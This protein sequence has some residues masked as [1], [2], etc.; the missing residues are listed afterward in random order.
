M[1]NLYYVGAF[2]FLNLIFVFFIDQIKNFI[3][4]FDKADGV[5]K[6]QEKPVAPIGGVIILFNLL[7]LLLIAFFDQNSLIFGKPFFKISNEFYLRGYFSFFVSAIVF[8]IIGLYDDKKNLKPIT[9]VFLLLFIS[10]CIILIDETLILK[11]LIFFSVN[12][13][14]ILNNFSYIFTILCILFLINAFNLYDGINLQSGINFIIIYVY[15][16]SKGIFPLLI[17]PFIIGNIFFLYLNFKNKIFFGDNGVYIN[18]FIIGYFVIKSYNHNADTSLKCDEVLLLFLLP[19]LDALRLFIFRIL[20]LKNPFV[21]DRN[22]IHHILLERLGNIYIVNFV[23]ALLVIIPLIFYN[24]MGFNLLEITFV[25]IIIYILI[26]MYSKF[27]KK[28]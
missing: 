5:R 18:S 19:T 15:L 8:F 11:E 23:L 28:I 21:G 17:L 2:I 26:L 9:K 25:V 7:I 3:N 14:I 20:N 27:F 1:N 22:H 10:L 16:L 4:I 12:H 24:F 13:T 6:F